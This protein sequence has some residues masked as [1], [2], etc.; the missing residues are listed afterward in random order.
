MT[1]QEWL[2]LLPDLLPLADMS[3]VLSSKMLSLMEQGEDQE[4][5]GLKDFAT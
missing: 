5:E 2:E 3:E 1:I 4:E